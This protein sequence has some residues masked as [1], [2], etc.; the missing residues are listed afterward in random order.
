M[1]SRFTINGECRGNKWLL[2]LVYV[3]KRERNGRQKEQAVNR[4]IRNGK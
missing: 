2:E 1:A 3:V 4:I